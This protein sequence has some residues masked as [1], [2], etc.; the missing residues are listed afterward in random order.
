MLAYV[1]RRL[2]MAVP[3]LIGVSV[4][5]FLIVH[6]APGDPAEIVA[7][8]TAPRDVVED[9]RRQLGLDQ[10][11]YV[12][13]WRYISR[14]VQGDLGR[15]LVTRRSVSDEIRRT[16][17]N[18]LELVVV[19]SAWSILAAIPLGVVAAVRR[20]SIFDKL[21]MAVALIGISF[22]IF[23]IGLVLL[24]LFAAYLGW[25]PISGRGGSLLTL[26]GW[27]HIAM[28]AF[29]LGYFQVA[30]LARVIRSSML[31]VLGQD[32]VRTARAKGLRDNTVVYR[33]ALRNALMPAVTV[34]GIQVGVLLGGAVVTETIFSWPGMG[35][36][37]VGAINYR[38]FPMVQG[39]ILVLAIAFVLI[40]LLVDITYAVLD[41]RI[42]YN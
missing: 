25:L 26:D 32:F 18:T 11:F 22:P 23:F 2:F 36:L 21:S 38:D 20:N 7:G 24:W 8:P 13:Y 35:R 37:V 14:A 39:P 5:V 1:V 42:R 15:S 34:I 17:P 6:I 33:H 27:K 29:T 30:A 3:V 19:S 40:N 4:L 9:V 31:E 12:Q 28:P 16:F 41:P 10:P